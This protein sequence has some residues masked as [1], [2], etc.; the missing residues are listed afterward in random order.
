M[1]VFTRSC[2]DANT[3]RVS[4]LMFLSPLMSYVFPF[5]S[6]TYD[7]VI[8]VSHQDKDFM[9]LFKVLNLIVVFF[10][11]FLSVVSL[12]TSPYYSCGKLLSIPNPKGL[13]LHLLFKIFTTNLLKQWFVF[14]VSLF[15]IDCDVK[16]F[17]KT[18]QYSH[19]VWTQ[20][21]IS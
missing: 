2:S 10:Y 12:I 21:N 20:S 7:I 15:R 8:E 17:C 9:F 16:D 1:F 18:I 3:L 19:V 14:F 11:F 4:P 5:S 13:T 6:F